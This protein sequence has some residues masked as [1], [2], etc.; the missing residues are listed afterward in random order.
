MQYRGPGV[1]EIGQVNVAFSKTDS[2]IDVKIK[3]VQSLTDEEQDE[4]DDEDDSI[5]PQDM[6]SFSWQIAQGMVSEKIFVLF[7]CTVSVVN[8][9]TG[10]FQL[11]TLFTS[12]AVVKP[13]KF[14]FVHS[15]QLLMMY[16]VFSN[17]YQQRALFIEISPLV[18]S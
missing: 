2:S 12:V 6:M 17:T 9:L 7:S 10:E 5:T 11:V 3:N 4:G 16:L 15:M 8:L 14:F 13:F 1:N 18:M